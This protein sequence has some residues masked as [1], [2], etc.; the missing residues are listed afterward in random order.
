[1]ML[2]QV[3]TDLI[4]KHACVVVPDF[5]GFISQR[6]PASLD[7]KSGKLLP[8]SKSILFNRQLIIS[9]G[10]LIGAYA[11][12]QA[13]SYDEATQEIKQ[14]V[15][16]WKKDLSLGNRVSI[17]HI[18][19]LYLDNT[20]QICFE[21][22]KFVNLLLSSYGLM[23]LSVTS[24]KTESSQEVKAIEFIDFNAVSET[25]NLEN[26]EQSEPTV[27][28]INFS[29][30]KKLHWTRYVAAAALLPVV[31]YSFWI[32]VKTNFLQSGIISIHDFN[33]F[34]KHHS[35][36][37]VL[38]KIE[39]KN[40]KQVKLN[41]VE[42]LIEQV[43][44]E[45]AYSYEVDG[46]NYKTILVNT[47]NQEKSVSSSTSVNTTT[48]NLNAFFLIGNCF[49]IED[50]AVNYTEELKAKGFDAQIVD[51]VNGLYRVSIGA[52]KSTEELE[53][54]KQE[55]RS[56]GISNFWILKK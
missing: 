9:D 3:I 27:L 30:T 40:I 34:N 7:F 32:P 11:N 51:Q 44:V 4:V 25:T 19:F 14:R 12:K 49:S 53:N 56:K 23:N 45:Q 16:E 21:Q 6:M 20:G 37:L 1:M 29:K 52:A 38:S 50:N 13:V 35:D 17:E 8:P 5:G 31:F 10:L 43:Q 22:D 39:K 36:E 42:K 41:N 18:G 48:N 54:V 46:N 26:K 55:V 2:E 24:A 47:K 28:A 15:S 33:P